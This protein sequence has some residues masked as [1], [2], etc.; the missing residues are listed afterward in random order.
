MHHPTGHPR[1]AHRPIVVSRR[2]AA[3]SPGADAPQGAAAPCSCSARAPCR[4][5]RCPCNARK[6]GLP[7]AAGTTALAARCGGLPVAGRA[8][9]RSRPGRGRSFPAL[10]SGRLRSAGSAA[11]GVVFD[12]ACFRPTRPCSTIPCTR[13]CAGPM[14]ALRKCVGARAD[15]RP[16]SRRSSRCPRRRRQRTGRSR[17]SPRAGYLRGRPVQ[18][19][20]AA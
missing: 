2:Q 4:S 15:T 11:V 20:R 17:R 19:R 1:A 13:R 7:E 10:S 12:A 14:R 5:G 8:G 3:L 16:T 18:R 6:A 9:K